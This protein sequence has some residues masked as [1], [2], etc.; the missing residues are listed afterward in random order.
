MPAFARYGRRKMTTVE[1]EL[2]RGGKTVHQDE[3]P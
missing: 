3:Y 2:L 1:L